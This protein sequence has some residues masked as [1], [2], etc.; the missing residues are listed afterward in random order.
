M[1]LR[2]A[3][4]A[5]L[6]TGFLATARDVLRSVG[7]TDEP[8]QAAARSVRR[9]RRGGSAASRRGGT[10]G[11]DL[12]SFTDDLQARARDQHEPTTR[13]VTL[14]TLHA[15]RDSSGIT[16]TSWGSARV[17]CPSRTPPRSRRSMRSGGSRTS[18][19]RARRARCR[20]AGPRSRSA[21]RSPSRFLRE[22]GTGSLRSV[23]A[24]SRP[25]RSE[26]AR[27][28]QRPR[29]RP[30]R[31]AEEEPGG[32]SGFGGQGDVDRGAGTPEQLCAHRGPLRVVSS[33]CGVEA[34]EAGRPSGHHDR[35]DDGAR[36][37][38]N[39][40]DVRHV[41]AHEPVRT[42][43]VDTMR[44]QKHH[45]G[46]RRHRGLGSTRP[47]QHARACGERCE[48]R[49]RDAFRKIIDDLHRDGVLAT[50][51]RQGRADGLEQGIAVARTCA[52]QEREGAHLG[53]RRADTSEATTGSTQGAMT[54]AKATAGAP[55]CTRP[56]SRQSGG[57]EESS[58]IMERSSRRRRS[59]TPLSPHS[60]PRGRL[61]RS[62]GRGAAVGHEAL[63]SG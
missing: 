62:R 59:R 42:T 53:V 46:R 37:V 3:S 22:I 5:P 31:R 35:P 29:R 33:A 52:V 25:R 18:G 34:G 10:A 45:P 16:S 9:G 50:P 38:E 58:R 7:M 8:P 32:A 56:S 43:R 21:E 63:C 61:G 24:A 20:S 19:S 4:V 54:G 49:A 15:A 57:A 11:T 40:R 30:D 39:E 60:A 36:P 28:A 14:A 51:G 47:G 1:A 44:R 26:S 41:V 13:T 48:H 12:R 23:G 17:C 27:S 6:E 55:N 2:A